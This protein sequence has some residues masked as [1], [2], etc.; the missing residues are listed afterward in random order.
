M[1]GNKLRCWVTIVVCAL[2]RHYLAAQGQGTGM[3]AAFFRF[4]EREE[5]GAPTNRQDALEDMISYLKHKKCL[6]S[7]KT[8]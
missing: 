5:K 6:S 3:I 1:I 2:Q 8:E 4:E 7:Q